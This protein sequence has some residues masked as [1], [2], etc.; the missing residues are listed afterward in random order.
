MG[1]RLPSPEGTAGAAQ[2][3]RGLG[4]VRGPV[5]CSLQVE[6]LL[7]WKLPWPKGVQVESGL[8]VGT[9]VSVFPLLS[10]LGTSPF[11]SFPFD[12]GLGGTTIP[13]PCCV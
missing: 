12:H 13:Q 4:D 1:P 10:V 8:Y 2:P 7:D 6:G 3:Q 9:L 5:L 11:G